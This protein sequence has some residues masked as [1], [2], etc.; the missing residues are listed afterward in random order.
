MK[1]FIGWLDMNHISIV[2]TLIVMTMTSL[3]LYFELPKD[4]FP[5]GDFPRFQVIA[6]IGFAFQPVVL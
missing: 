1:K 6:D 4:V 2:F 3:W 5:N